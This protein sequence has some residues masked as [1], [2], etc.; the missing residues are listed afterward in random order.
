MRQE[1]TIAKI[2]ITYSI[3]L[4]FAFLFSESQ[5]SLYPS[6]ILHFIPA[7]SLW[8]RL[9]WVSVIGSGSSSKLS[10][11]SRIQTWVSR[12]YSDIVTT[13][14]QLW[15]SEEG[16]IWNTTKPKIINV[17]APPALPPQSSKQHKNCGYTASICWQLK[18]HLGHVCFERFHL[19]VFLCVLHQNHEWENNWKELWTYKALT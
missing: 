3:N 17:I 14:L 4:Y 16:G 11:Q 1:G 10:W 7:T 13:M 18:L 5:N 9:G 19:T 2:N 12:S 8:C 6:L 15:K